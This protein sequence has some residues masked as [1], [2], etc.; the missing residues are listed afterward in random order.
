MDVLTLWGYR[1]SQGDG[2]W[3]VIVIEELNQWMS[4]QVRRYEGK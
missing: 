2:K 3:E 4:T 1:D